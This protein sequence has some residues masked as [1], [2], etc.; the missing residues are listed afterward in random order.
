MT[1]RSLFML[2]SPAK[3]LFRK[4]IHVLLQDCDKLIHLVHRSE[5]IRK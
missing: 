1:R 4:S 5:F 3:A 2:F